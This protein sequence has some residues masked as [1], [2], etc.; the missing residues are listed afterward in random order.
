MKKIVV[1]FLAL[2]MA[3]CFCACGGKGGDSSS[4]VLGEPLTAED[5]QKIEVVVGQR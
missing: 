2:T 5:E 3:F 1:T 4:V